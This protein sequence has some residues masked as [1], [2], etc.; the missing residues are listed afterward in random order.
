MRTAIRGAWVVGYTKNG[1]VLHR[2]G[3]V[4]VEGDAVVFVGPGFDGAVDRTI[5]RTDCIVA[6]GFVDTHVH[7]GLRSGHRLLQDSG[8]QEYFGQ[9]RWHFT[10]ARKGTRIPPEPPSLAARYT[11]MEL[12]CNGT[13][14]LVE[15]GLVGSTDP[16]AAVDEYERSGL[17]AYLG[18]MF[19]DTF[20][21]GDDNGRVVRDLDVERGQRLLAAAREF[22]AAVDGRSGGR[23]RGLVVPRESDTCSPAL[24]RASRK[25][26]D[27]YSVPLTC[28]VAYH[29]DEFF[30][31]V[32]TY[33]CTPVELLESTG[34]LGDDVLLGH[35]NLPAESKLTNYA[36]G[37]DLALIAGAGATVAHCP[38]NLVRRGR[39]LDDWDSY[40]SA[41]VR[42]ALGT[43]TWPRDMML[44]MRIASYLGK[45]LSGSYLAT[46]AASVYEAA[47]LGG[48]NALGREDLGRLCP[49]AKADIIAIK[50]SGLRWG[51]VRD[52]IKSLVDCGCGDDVD[53]VMVD[54]N[55]LMDG[56]ASMT[57][58]I[59]QLRVEAQ[60]VSQAAWDQVP[61]WDP[62][63]RSAEEVS[64]WSFPIG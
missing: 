30:H 32:R 51:A 44:Q 53:F 4:V 23:L 60:E 3:V 15:A 42:M 8:R 37:R 59:E 61:D 55:V 48:A 12:L 20:L 18:L 62:L 58:T 64:P 35:C 14:T 10:V 26:A 34:V 24:L 22:I 19:E 57:A 11:A 54:G 41:G 39:K 50:P 52:P 29:P 49:G 31:I 43:D 38:V 45:V 2:D 21:H 63:G 25:M 17:R 6:P 36:G 56:R 9:P 5:D 46:P 7:G 28:H 33:G 16:A 27:E 13:T 47:T 40:A 1:H